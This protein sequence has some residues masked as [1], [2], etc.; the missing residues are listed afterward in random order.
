MRLDAGAGGGLAVPC[1]APGLS[2]LS[3]HLW[4]LVLSPSERQAGTRQLFSHYLYLII[5]FYLRE[6]PAWFPG[7]F[8]SVLSR[9][10]NNT[11]KGGSV[12]VMILYIHSPKRDNVTRMPLQIHKWMN[13]YYN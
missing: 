12:S 11:H 1:A 10:K 8:T 6:N 5:S 4:H 2:T 7:E 9:S 3:Q 13:S